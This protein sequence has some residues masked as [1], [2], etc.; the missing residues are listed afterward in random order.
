[1]SRSNGDGNHLTTTSRQRGEQDAHHVGGRVDLAQRRAGRA[2]QESGRNAERGREPVRIARRLVREH[3]VL[4]ECCI[5]ERGDRIARLDAERRGHV[6]TA[7]RCD[8]LAQQLEIAVRDRVCQKPLDVRR[9]RRLAD[10]EADDPL[11]RE[12]AEADLRRV[13]AA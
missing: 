10:A 8:V 4:G 11:R 12:R 6:V 9:L 13:R 7:V 1:M 5:R 2:V 3:Q